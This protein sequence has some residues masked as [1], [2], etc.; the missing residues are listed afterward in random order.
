MIQITD[1][2]KCCGCE[3]CAQKCPRQCIQMRTDKEGFWYPEVNKIECIDCG[4]C[5]KVC[6]IINSNEIKRPLKVYAAI[7]PNEEIRQNSSSGGIFSLLAQY[8]LSE[9]GVIFGAKFNNKQEVIHGY[10]EN[11]EELSAFRGSKY[12][13]SRIGD[14]YKQAEAFLKVG[15]KVLFSGTSCQIAGLHKFL[16]K[17]Y[18]NLLTIDVVCH[19]VPSP[20]VWK[21]YYE[22]VLLK[23]VVK[24]KG[25]GQPIISDMYISF[26]DKSNGW[27]K[28]NFLVKNAHDTLY[29]E[30][31]RENPFMK[32]FL[33]NISLR[34]SCY[35]CPAK[36]G[37]SGSDITLGDYWGIEHYYP[38][39]DDDKGTSLVMINTEKGFDIFLQMKC[40]V[41]ETTYV[42]TFE[43][44]P[45]IERS[46]QEPVWRS[47]FFK[48]LKKEDYN[49]AVESTLRKMRPSIIARIKNKI[50]YLLANKTK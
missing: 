24:E 26:R 50:K 27:K 37:K 29:K 42:Q 2:Y 41:Q 36:L 31:F 10:C 16:R 13:Q 23:K 30:C 43:Y 19:G 39:M 48:K 34:P 6:P 38:E 12:V 25:G 5:E 15:R 40:K 45:F 33:Q 14:S 7:N 28:Y 18:E 17:E 1:K 4:L 49:Q 22:E 47:F 9:E 21:K 46:V 35:A 32:I 8:V 44:N 20:L 11:V 3:A